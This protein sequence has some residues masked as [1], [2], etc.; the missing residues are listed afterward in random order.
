MRGHN[1]KNLVESEGSRTI[2]TKLRRLFEK[3]ELRPE[4]VSVQELWESLVGPMPKTLS[5]EHR[6]GGHI[7]QL[8]EA[9]VDTTAFADVMG[10][11][12]MSRAMERYNITGYVGELLTDTLQTNKLSERA[13]GFLLQDATAEVDEGMPY[14]EAG[15]SDQYVSFL[16]G[17]KRG[18]LLSITEE[19]IFRDETGWL[20]RRAGDIGEYVRADKETRI[21][22]VVTGTTT[23]YRINGV[24][25]A[26][27]SA[28]AA[29][30]GGHGNLQA[31]NALVDW[32]DIDVVMKLIALQRGAD[33]TTSITIVPKQLVV[34]YALYAT[35]SRI[36]RATSNDYIS[37]V[38]AAAGT[39]DA[40]Y[41]M[42]GGNP[43]A[44]MFALI[45]TPRL[46]G[47]A[48]TTWYM[49][50]FKRALLYR[51]HWPFQSFKRNANTEDGFKRD[52]AV[53]FK[54][55]EWGTSEVIDHRHAY[56]STA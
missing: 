12:L 50:D 30:A 2:A 24:N 6:R 34:P 28:T 25:T 41:V 38:N 3:G 4:D 46:D 35:A 14:P 18:I 39:A 19:A 33:T 22:N 9:A 40:Q 53:Q 29:S 1:L 32:T 31:T 55:R 43:Y 7:M 15:M 13:P 16:S 56:Q 52:I 44:G 27:Y 37:R 49:G 8:T 21:L 23:A 47:Y 42:T 17:K 5:F 20:L 26:L 48:T 11:V 45:T 51:E 10:Q 54:F 36:L